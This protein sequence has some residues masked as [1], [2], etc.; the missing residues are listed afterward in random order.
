MIPPRDTERLGFCFFRPLFLHRVEG[1]FLSL[2]MSTALF[3][4]GYL[5]CAQER[6]QLSQRTYRVDI[7]GFLTTPK[8]LALIAIFFPT[9]LISV[10]TGSPSLITVPVMI[11]FG[12]EPHVAVATNMMALV[13]VSIGGSLAFTRKGILVRERLPALII[14][15]IFGSALGACF[16]LAIPKGTF[17]LVIA[18]AMVGI[19]IFTL[20]RKNA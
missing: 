3:P 5:L 15:T 7:I 17:Q 9:S 8:L 4:L 13:F 16:L 10:V 11:Q 18:V 6:K 1:F 2:T 12:I 20:T 14:I 19:A